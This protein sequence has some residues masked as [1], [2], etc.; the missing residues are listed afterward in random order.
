MCSP[1]MA[2]GMMGMGVA[3]STFGAYK[4][5]QAQKASLTYEAAV[6]QNNAQVADMQAKL[7]LQDGAMQEQNQE[8]K[9]ASV[10]GD[11]R[12]ALAAN[13]VDLG[14]GSP[15]EILAT[16][17]FMGTRDSLQLRDNAA[18]TAWAYRNQSKSYMGES[19]ADT[20]ASDAINPMTVASTSFLTNASKVA[21]SWYAYD[22]S[23]N[24]TKKP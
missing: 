24:G 2:G 21:A 4:S 1:T 14:E 16:T 20:A 11:Q 22:K 3:A 17:K 23:V 7:A 19:A 10:M 13:G 15:N 18:R 5:A 12:A 8:L 6:A 9:T